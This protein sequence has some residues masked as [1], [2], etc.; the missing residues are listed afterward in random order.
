MKIDETTL[1]GVLM[2][3]PDIHRDSRGAFWETW[4]QRILTEAGLPSVWTQDNFSMTN[5]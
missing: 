3:T 2:L 4:N 1:P 5:T